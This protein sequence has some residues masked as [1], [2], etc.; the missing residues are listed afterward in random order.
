MPK[1]RRAREH[2]FQKIGPIGWLILFLVFFPVVFFFKELRELLVF[3]LHPNLDPPWLRAISLTLIELLTGFLAT[4]VLWVLL[5]AGQ[6]LVPV[7]SFNERVRA[8]WHLLLFIFGRHGIATAVR[9]GKIM[10]SRKPEGEYPGLLII[11]F[12]SAVVLEEKTPIPDLSL[13][14]TS[15][16][17]GLIARLG[18][19]D[20][21]ESPRVAG[22]GLV[23]LRPMVDIHSVIDVRPQIRNRQDVCAYTRDGIEVKTGVSALFSVGQ[24]PPLLTFT[25]DGVFKVENMHLV[26]LDET[27]DGG[28]KINQVRENFQDELDPDDWIEIQER[29]TSLSIVQ[30]HF[31]YSLQPRGSHIPIFNRRR[32]FSAAFSDALDEK[33]NGIPWNELPVKVACDMY[34]QLLLEFNYDQLYNLQDED[35][36][37]LQFIRSQLRLRVR[38]NGLLSFRLLMRR[39]RRP[40]EPGALLQPDELYVSQ[41]FPLMSPKVLRNAGIA[42][43]AS[44]FGDL[45]PNELVY[46]QRLD[47][48]RARWESETQVIEAKNELDAIRERTRARLQTQQELIRRLHQVLNNASQS[49]EATAIQFYMEL[50]ALTRDPITSKLLPNETVLLMRSVGDWI[51]FKESPPGPG[52]LGDGGK[53]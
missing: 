34:R 50:E 11:D 2:V 32:V 33:G 46:Q 27:E 43:F 9:D 39:D 23:F 35:N 15:M 49:P 28:V 14:I 42:V 20:E 12:N 5:V 37:P 25:F 45:I 21:P 41:V 22:P 38:N 8:G 6:A 16:R 40:L 3:W 4:F 7:N 31:H 26:D 18:L 36:Y 17:N 53:L 44:N 24:P 10:T 48:W 51:N 30:A 13:P 19:M 52:L 1:R 29:L 47:S